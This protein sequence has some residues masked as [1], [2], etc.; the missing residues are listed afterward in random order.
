MSSEIT[1]I[2]DFD[3]DIGLYYF[4]VKEGQATL[5]FRPGF[6]TQEEAE[7]TGDQWIRDHLNATPQDSSHNE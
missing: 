6:R 5:H 7:H 3:P 4:I 2:T 1:L